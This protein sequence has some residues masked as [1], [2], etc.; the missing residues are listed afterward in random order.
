MHRNLKAGVLVL[1][2][3]YCAVSWSQTPDAPAPKPPMNRDVFLVLV[4][5]SM[6]SACDNPQSPYACMT[7]DIEVCRKKL[8]I[9]LDQCEK[10]MKAQLPEEIKS[11]ERRQWS[12]LVARCLLDDYIV[13]AGAA[14]IDITKCSSRKPRDSESR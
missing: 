6:N 13:L 9:A 10:K 14:N 11:E 7:K 8:P 1:A 3:A 5:S 2:S 4:K 12:N